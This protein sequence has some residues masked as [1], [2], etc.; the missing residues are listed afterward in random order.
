MRSTRRGRDDPDC[1]CSS[2]ALLVASLP[3][4]ECPLYF[5]LMRVANE[6]CSRSSQQSTKSD[7]KFCVPPTELPLNSRPFSS[8][9]SAHAIISISNGMLTIQR[10]FSPVLCT[11]FADSY[12]HRYRVSGSDDLSNGQAH[13]DAEV[14]TTFITSP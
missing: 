2:R 1:E 13:N 4:W 8:H 12:D 7:V 9:Q 14:C 11:T 3:L 10:T 6:I 5:R